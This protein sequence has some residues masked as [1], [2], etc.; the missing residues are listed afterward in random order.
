L[1]RLLLWGLL[2]SRG[3]I[4]GLLNRP[5]VAL[6]FILLLLFGTLALCRVNYHSGFCKAAYCQSKKKDDG[7]SN[8]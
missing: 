7:N 3:I 2:C 8:K 4:A 6:E 5:L 1:G